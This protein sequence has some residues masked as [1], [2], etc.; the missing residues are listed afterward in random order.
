MAKDLALEL[1]WKQRVEEYR[2]SSLSIRNWCRLS[3]KIN[4]FFELFILK[5]D[6]LDLEKQNLSIFPKYS[7]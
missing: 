1:K 7:M 4:T 3:S 5:T 6:P 2:Q